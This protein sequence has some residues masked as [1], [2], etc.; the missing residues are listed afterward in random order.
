[1]LIKLLI[2][3]VAL[4]TVLSQLLLKRVVAD[5]GGP[6]SFSE[7]SHFI[8]AAAASPWV[9]ASLALQVIGYVLWMV[10]ISHEKLGIAIALLGGGFY[11]SMAFAAWILYG[12][13][14]SAV[15]WA[16]IGFVTFGV[17]CLTVQQV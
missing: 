6:T 1:M 2:V 15:Q 10:V 7:F 4:N 14:L 17:G 13:E 8:I 3:G 16:G 11:I 9:Y 12:E 5:I